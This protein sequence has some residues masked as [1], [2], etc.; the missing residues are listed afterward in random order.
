MLIVS[1]S[2]VPYFENAVGK[3]FIDKV[4]A[5]TVADV[6]KVDPALSTFA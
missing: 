2:G 6:S 1:S 4:W 3:A 5:E